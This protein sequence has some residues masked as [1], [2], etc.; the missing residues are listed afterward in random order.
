MDGMEIK[1]VLDSPWKWEAEF[2][3]FLEKWADV[4]EVAENWRRGI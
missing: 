2:A 4:N 3:E 1:W